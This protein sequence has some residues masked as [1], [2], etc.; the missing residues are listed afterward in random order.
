M[1]PGA[2]LQVLGLASR[3]TGFPGG[4]ATKFWINGKPSDTRA[5]SGVTSTGTVGGRIFGYVSSNGTNNI[6]DIVE[7]AVF[8]GEL[9]DAQAQTIAD[10]LT[11]RW[12]IATIARTVTLEGDSITQ[13]ITEVVSG[14]NVAMA[15]TEPGASLVPSNARVLNMA[16]SGASCADLV[17][18]RDIANGWPTTKIGASANDNILAVQI[19]RN[20]NAAYIALGNTAAAAAALTYAD[21]L[22]YH[23]TAVTGTVA[24]GWKPIQFGNIACDSGVTGTNLRDLIIASFATDVSGGS[25]I[26][27]QQIIDSAGGAGRKPFAQVPDTR[28]GTYYQDD[29]GSLDTTHPSISGD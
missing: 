27:L 10:Y 6:M 16:V 11:S 1:V 14:D 4:D 23:N 26:D 5:Q 24:R 8:T 19:G 22:A 2:Q 28:D 25:V 20:D 7:M 29:D 18:R 13:G 12:S 17:T 3:T 15:I 21:I 9:T